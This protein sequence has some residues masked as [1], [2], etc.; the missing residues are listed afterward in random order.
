[1]ISMVDR[2]GYCMNSSARSKFHP[3]IHDSLQVFPKPTAIPRRYLRKLYVEEGFSTRQIAEI[4]SVSRTTVSAALE[5]RG[6]QR[7]KTQARSPENYSCHQ[8]APYGWRSV[9]G[10][11]IPDPCEAKVVRLARQLR[12]QEGRS[13][14]DHPRTELQRML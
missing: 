4:L 12:S 1:M 3:K 7:T 13:A 11:L 5:S 2:I 14:S 9:A 8:E 10:T 6:I